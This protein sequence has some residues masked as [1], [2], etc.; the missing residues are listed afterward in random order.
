MMASFLVWV[1]TCLVHSALYEHIL[2]TKR[3]TVCIV[4][5]VAKLA[6]EFQMFNLEKE[7]FKI[8]DAKKFQTK[9]AYWVFGCSR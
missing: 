5:K 3:G 7:I 2:I 9:Y 8:F 6:N 4:E 1:V